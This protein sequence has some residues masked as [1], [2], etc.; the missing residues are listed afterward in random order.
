MDED[1]P[2]AAPART[3]LPPGEGRG[4]VR[5]ASAVSSTRPSP[6]R[7][8]SARTETGSRPWSR[9]DA[10]AGVGTARLLR[11]RMTG[12]E[13]KIWVRLRALRA[14]GFHFRRQVPIGRFI[15][16]F[17]C[18]KAGLVVEIDGGQHGHD[19]HL[20][21]DRAR[22]GALSAAGFKVVRFWNAE[23]DS[24]PDAVI[25]TIFAHLTDDR[26]ALRP[27]PPRPSPEGRE[28][29]SRGEET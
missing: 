28:G 2:M 21:R 10:I 24:D 13:T 7:A 6:L 5:R 29:G 18:L 17:A 4:G 1:R 23:V 16:D 12:Q 22:D 19:A 26:A 14:Q 9:P 25:D 11:K 3:S 15:V 27:T 8:S 20:R